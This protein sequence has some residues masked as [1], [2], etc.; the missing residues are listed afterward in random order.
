MVV[1]GME[2]NRWLEQG[3]EVLR[4]EA[5]AVLQM[6]DN[7]GEGFVRAVELLQ[8]CPGRVVVTGI[9]KSGQVGRKLA[10]T[11]AS[12][13]TPAYFVHAAEAVH[14]DL[15][16]ICPGDVVLVLSNSGETA[17]VLA[18]LP[19]LVRSGVSLIA[20]TGRPGS[21]LGRASEVNL[22]TGVT[23]EADPLGLAPTTST[24]AALALGDALAVTLS[25]ARGFTRED[26]ALYHPGGS[27]G[28]QLAGDSQ[29][30][31]EAGA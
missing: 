22:V 12:T 7:L 24:T 9:G 23:A 1:T 2:S 3:R 10:A 21:T 31:G 5:A 20:L 25:V 18:L 13:G 16:M 29:S 30:E 4:R 15:G 28:R 11:F 19:A 17:E 14:G 27:L 6:S 8:T 26:F